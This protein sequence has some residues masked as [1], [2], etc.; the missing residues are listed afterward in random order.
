[1]ADSASE[2]SGWR[3][4]QIVCLKIVVGIVADGASEISGRGTL[5]DGVSEN[6]GL[7]SGIWFI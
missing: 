2:N 1:M 5:A 7:N 6:S 3:H 4:W